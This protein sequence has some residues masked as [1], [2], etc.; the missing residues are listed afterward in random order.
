L[1]VS[2]E[3]KEQQVEDLKQKLGSAEVVILTDFR[4]LSVGDQQ[5]LRTRLRDSASDYVVVK[6]TLTKIA[7]EQSDRPV[8]AAY[9][10][11]PT[12]LTFLHEDIAAP[13]KALLDFAKETGVLVIKGGIVGRPAAARGVAGPTD[14][15]YPGTVGDSRCRTGGTGQRAGTHAT[16]ANARAR[17]DHSGVCRSESISYPLKSQTEKED[18]ESGRKQQA[19]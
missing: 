15:G 4:G 3:K 18:F 16:S 1:A 13:T 7:L 2:R 8:P 14:R 19:G 5:E 17:T 10:T 9:L 11:G 6:N 12:A